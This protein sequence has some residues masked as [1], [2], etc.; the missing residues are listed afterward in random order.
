MVLVATILIDS[1]RVWIGIVRGTRE[2]RVC[3]AP[4]VISQ[5]R[6]EEL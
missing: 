1:A 6:P 4:F 3:E 5:L 2:A